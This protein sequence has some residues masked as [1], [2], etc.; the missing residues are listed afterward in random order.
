MEAQFTP[1]ISDYVAAIKRRHFLILAIALPI[2]AIAIA[3]A[4]G[5]PS[6]YVSSSLI[7]FSR[8]TVPDAMQSGKAV[9]EQPAYA[10]QQ[11]LYAD[12]YVAN[13]RQAVLNANDLGPVAAQVRGLPT[14]PSNPGAAIAAIREHASMQ[15]VRTKVLDPDSGRERVIVTAFSVAFSSR[16]PRTA[17][18]VAAALTNAVIDASRHSMLVRA[19]NAG[20]FYDSEAT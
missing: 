14:I 19:R 7:E 6:T 9:M 12:Q 2:V 15:S 17:Q 4:I 1:D 10:D 16:N 5:L 18:A 3:L 8:A 20:Q 13:M 11:R